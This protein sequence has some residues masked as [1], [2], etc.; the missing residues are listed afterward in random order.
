MWLLIV[1]IVTFIILLVLFFRA[2]DFDQF[3]FSFDIETTVVDDIK[4]EVSKSLEQKPTPKKLPASKPQPKKK[5]IQ[6]DQK[7][8]YLTVKKLVNDK[9]Y[10]KALSPL[11]ELLKMDPEVPKYWYEKS[12]PYMAC[13]TA[14]SWVQWKNI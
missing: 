6:A 10:K 14:K 13:T 7:E 12:G 8:L 11:N 3:E 4:R 2:L 5:E 9:Q 1:L